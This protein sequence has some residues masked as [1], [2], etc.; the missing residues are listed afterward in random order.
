M[1][2]APHP[3]RGQRKRRSGRLSPHK[4]HCSLRFQRLRASIEYIWH[5]ASHHDTA[6]TDHRRIVFREAGVSALPPTRMYARWTPRAGS[7]QLG[8]TS[9]PLTDPLSLRR[10]RRVT[11]HSHR[12]QDAGEGTSQ[13][14]NST[15]AAEFLNV[16]PLFAVS[17]ST[18]CGIWNSAPCGVGSCGVANFA[19]CGVRRTLRSL[20]APSA[21]QPNISSLQ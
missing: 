19:P 21:S 10:R 14:R 9:S 13:C 12:S 1:E 5:H 18:P 15:T 11:A 16:T 8:G 2:S 17:N 20:L 6:H 3:L 7:R 4:E